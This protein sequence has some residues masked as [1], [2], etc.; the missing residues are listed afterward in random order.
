MTT[1]PEGTSIRHVPHVLPEIILVGGAHRMLNLVGGA[2][3]Y[4]SSQQ[5][6]LRTRK[7][8]SDSAQLDSAQL[9][10]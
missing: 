4:Y 5:V 1:Q 2:H 3:E 7:Y 6:Q 8:Y 10:L 9:P